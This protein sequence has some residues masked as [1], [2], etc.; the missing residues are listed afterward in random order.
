MF[1]AVAARLERAKADVEEEGRLRIQLLE[2]KTSAQ[3]AAL[4]SE[5]KTQYSLAIGRAYEKLSQN[6]VVYKSYRELYNLSLVRPHR[7]VSFS[8]FSEGEVRAMD[9][10]MVSPSLSHTADSEVATDGSGLLAAT[11]SVVGSRT[12]H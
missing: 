4:V 9:A 11:D 2:A 7:T 12:T 8:G 6:A 10:A 5:A 3:V 1:Q